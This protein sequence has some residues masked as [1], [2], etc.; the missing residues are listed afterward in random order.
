MRVIPLTIYSPPI[1]DNNMQHRDLSRGC[2]YSAVGV[3]QS[4]KI[5]HCN[6]MSNELLR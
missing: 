2:Y 3:A 1:V 5:L 6:E 4:S